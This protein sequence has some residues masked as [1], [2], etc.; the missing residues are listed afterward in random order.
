MSEAD[1]GADSGRSVAM[2]AAETI[3]RPGIDQQQAVDTAPLVLIVEDEGPIAEAIALIVRDAGF[4]PMVAADGLQALEMAGAHPPALVITDLMM[5]R[6]DGAELI[7]ALRSRA[8]LDGGSAP[9]TVLVTAA[10]LRRAEAAGA[11]AVLRKPFD[12][13]ALDRLLRRFLG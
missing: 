7:A 4:E 12:M 8:A 11:D 1:T 10:G 9:P 6:L 13:A 5:P 3:T 2:G